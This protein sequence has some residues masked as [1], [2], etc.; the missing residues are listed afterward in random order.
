[1]GKTKK[2]K[3]S[4]NGGK[5]K[6][7]KSETN[8]LEGEHDMLMAQLSAKMKGLAEEA[9][10]KK[11][12]P[13]PPEM[14]NELKS[15][16]S[17]MKDLMELQD[18]IRPETEEL[19][20]E[21]KKKNFKEFGA[22]LKEHAPKC[23]YEE[24][25]QFDVSVSEGSGVSATKDLEE[26]EEFIALP[27][28]VM[29]TTDSVLNT[30]IGPIVKVD[31]LCN[32]IPSVSLALHLLYESYEGNDSFWGPYIKCLPNKFDLPLFYTPKHFTLLQ[33]SNILI[34]IMQY[35]LGI[36][37]Q[38]LHIYDVLKK[39]SESE[40]DA[41]IKNLR[42]PM[43]REFRWAICVVMSRQ[44]MIPPEK[45]PEPDEK[46]KG[47]PGVFALIPGWDFCNHRFGSINTQ[48]EPD[49]QES[50]SYTME[51][52]KAGDPIYM[53]YGDRGY[54][55]LLLYM[56]FIPDGNRMNRYEVMGDFDPR[57]P[58]AKI[59]SMIAQKSRLQQI[60]KLPYDDTHFVN[61]DD[62]VATWKKR[63]EAIDVEIKAA[64]ERGEK[65]ER[66]KI[67]QPKPHWPIGVKFM[68]PFFR[69]LVLNKDEAGD[70]LKKMAAL[71][72]EKKHPLTRFVSE[73]NEAETRKLIK[74]SLKRWT[75][76][77]QKHMDAA[78]AADKSGIAEVD[79]RN[80]MKLH[81]IEMELLT[82]AAACFEKGFV[83]EDADEEKLKQKDAEEAAAKEAED[84]DD[85]DDDGEM[86]QLLA[87]VEGAKI[88]K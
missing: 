46:P 30:K 50:V 23:Q 49:R 60:M 4:G 76:Q 11:R 5:K 24:K 33:G 79:A 87:D 44:N 40:E 69:I 27:R 62:E 75:E 73:R 42:L 80:I 58:L 28:K 45:L 85:N 6:E 61:Y 36:I 10:R 81:E 35:Q 64:E 78:V 13:T 38:Y 12:R 39:V 84:D 37:R 2:G 68:L 43:F 25:Y 47:P 72:P 15:L 29:L 74:A 17:Y 88:T 31:P 77:K 71:T 86:P 57:D 1:M 20:V 7:P 8:V 14:E 56:G 21:E 19:S 32:E 9:Q 52:V 66:P 63:F 59:K 41:T 48:F 53:H 70:V 65:V 67:S 16:Q 18:K 22:W 54:K 83:I 55:D 3:K 51:A 26:S 34:S 82:N